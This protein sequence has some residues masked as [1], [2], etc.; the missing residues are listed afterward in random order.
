M[1]YLLERMQEPST[2]RG[3]VMLATG[4]GVAISPETIEQVVVAGTAITGLIGMFTKD[5]RRR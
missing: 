1:R 2:W 3:L 5:D 4:L